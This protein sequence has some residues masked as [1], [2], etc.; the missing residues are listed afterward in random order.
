VLEA[1]KAQDRI[2]SEYF[3]PAW[4]HHV[5]LLRKVGAGEID[6][7]AVPND[8]ITLM[9]RHEPHYARF[10]PR[11]IMNEAT[12]FII[13]SVGST[14]NSLC[15]AVADLD[16]WFRV[17]PE[18]AQ[19][20]TDPEF[21]RHAYAE[22]LRL[23]QDNVLYRTA[24]ADETLP[25][26]MVI[27]EGEVVACDRIVANTEL[28]VASDSDAGG[29]AFDPHRAMA[30]GV[31]QYGLAFGDG[32]HVCIGRPMVLDRSDRDPSAPNARIGT[33]AMMLLELFKAGVDIPLDD[34]P[35]V[36]GD[37]MQRKSWKTFPVVFSLPKT[38]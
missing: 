12:L 16:A 23:G 37:M 20:A 22:S 19:L 21:I 31:A 4:E 28:A 32:V 8:L 2:I 5:E 38:D 33:G 18:D 25:S 9:L 34:R 14:T 10:S 35:D 27:K 24:M 29:D 30:A 11:V 13:A 1:L 26:G 7:S 17:H 15:T 6:E 36:H 3:D